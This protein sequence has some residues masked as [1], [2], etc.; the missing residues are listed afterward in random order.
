M[1]FI[2]VSKHLSVP[3]NQLFNSVSGC[4]SHRTLLIDQFIVCMRF[5]E[6]ELAN[7]RREGGLRR[8]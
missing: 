6:A 8:R 5:W 3:R 4:S 1:F 2:S 7:D